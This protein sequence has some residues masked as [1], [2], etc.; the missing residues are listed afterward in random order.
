VLPAT[1]QFDSYNE[2]ED[3]IGQVEA[4]K[5][6]HGVYPE[7]VHADNTY[8][9]SNNQSFCRKY[10]IRLSG[11]PLRERFSWDLSDNNKQVSLS[12]LI[13][14]VGSA[15]RLWMSTRLV[16]T[17]SSIPTLETAFQG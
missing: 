1:L 10:A 7:S 13:F 15:R 16:P 14:V 8:R 12:L 2:C 9:N 17:T 11:A 6:R 3:I 4:Y 5:E